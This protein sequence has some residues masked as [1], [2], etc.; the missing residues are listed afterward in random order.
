M[1]IC[2]Y[3]EMDRDLFESQVKVWIVVEHSSETEHLE[4]NNE[5]ARYDDLH[6]L[7]R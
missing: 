5:K 2:N 1:Q 3:N 4:Q 6:N 7:G